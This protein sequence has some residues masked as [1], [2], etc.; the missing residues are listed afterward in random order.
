MAV[1]DLSCGHD[2]PP[3]DSDLADCQLANSKALRGVEID[4][5]GSDVG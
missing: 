2:I 5:D 3:L 1:H 4:A